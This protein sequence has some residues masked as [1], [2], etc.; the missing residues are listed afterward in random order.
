MST[1][2]SNN[3]IRI[4]R[5]YRQFKTPEG[6]LVKALDGIDLTIAKN[7]FITLLG[8][9]GCGKTTVLKIIAGF[10]RL[11][12]G[13]V[14]IENKSILELP[15]HK[16]PVNTVF[17]SY[18]LFP[19]MTIEDNVGYGLDIAKIKKTE[20]NQRVKE[21]LEMVGLS[22]TEKRMPSQLSGGQQQ[23]VA[24]ARAIINRPKLLLLDEPL[25]ALD[26]NLRLKMQIELKKLQSELGICFIFVTH[27]QEEALTMSDRIVV[28]NE[29]KVQQ[30]GTPDEIYHTPKNRFVA[31]FMGESNLF[32]GKIVQIEKGH[33]TIDCNG[34][35]LFCAENDYHIGDQ[36][37]VML[38]PEQLTLA[39]TI[40]NN[41]PQAIELE[42]M[43]IVFIGTDY[44]LHGKLSN[45][46]SISALVR[47]GE[48]NYNIGDIVPLYYQINLIHVISLK[49]KTK[50]VSA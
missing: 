8:P 12:D 1:Y 27:D 46:Q 33:A 32:T 25:S 10:E 17:Q 43:E 5:G 36:V 14:L 49:R 7:E 23:R 31:T 19:H 44:Q 22:G 6:N 37:E 38:R 18:A 35:K 13:D 29:G 4:R 34:V 39:P 11:D 24:L 21:T 2:I 9:S 48:G 28:L 3:Y 26:K 45:G 20:R 30:M 47:K 50:Q 15:A 40:S 42:V 41:L 16:R